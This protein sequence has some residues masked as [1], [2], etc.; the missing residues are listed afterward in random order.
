[1]RA[2]I[3]AEIDAAIVFAEASPEPTIESLMDNV[4]SD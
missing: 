3:Q 4:Y 2:D 1:M